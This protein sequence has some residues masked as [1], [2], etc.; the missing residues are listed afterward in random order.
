MLSVHIISGTAKGKK[1]IAPE[2]HATRP[3]PGRVKEA[4]F[5]IIAAYVPGAR[6]LDLFAGTGA[7][8]LEALSRG[9]QH[10]TFVDSGKHA[11]SALTQ[12]C[13]AFPLAQTS[14]LA[15]PAERALQ[16]LANRQERFD[17]V[18]LD[19]PFAL[20]LLQATMHK[21]VQLSLLADD[22]LVVCEHA[23]STKSEEL[24]APPSCVCLKTRKMGDV[25]LTIFNY[26][27][28]GQQE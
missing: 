25:T 27:A 1:L 9:A 22:S 3:T 21:L 5:S 18:F 13:K 14:V 7:L 8:G 6:V 16:Q 28:A 17:L 2:G 15:M 4:L 19:P 12:N 10:A 24:V 20:D 11:L 23:S 26:S